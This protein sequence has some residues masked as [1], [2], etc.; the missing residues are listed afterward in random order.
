MQNFG[1][2]IFNFWTPH[3]SVWTWPRLPPAPLPPPPTVTGE[4]A[5]NPLA[6]WP[7]IRRWLSCWPLHFRCASSMPTSSETAA[8]GDWE[9]DATARHCWTPAF[10]DLSL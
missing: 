6:I 1:L 4:V 10:I 9:W 5:D 2:H 8:V 3:F 7:L